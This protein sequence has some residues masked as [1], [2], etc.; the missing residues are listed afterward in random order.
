MKKHVLTF[1][2]KLKLK[3]SKPL[4]GSSN[5]SFFMEQNFLN[6]ASQWHLKDLRLLNSGFQF[7]HID[8][9]TIMSTRPTCERRALE[10]MW[11]TMEEKVWPC[12]R[13]GH[14]GCSTSGALFKFK[15]TATKPKPKKFQSLL[16]R[17]KKSSR[18]I[19]KQRF[20][21][22]RNSRRKNVHFL[23]ANC[24]RRNRR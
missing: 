12:G 22:S 19:K 4:S 10:K 17:A 24:S 7:F 8:R 2:W 23:R 1:S 9:I 18:T 5:C 11:K 21:S 6:E 16:A 13:A 15:P 20:S 14:G 3:L